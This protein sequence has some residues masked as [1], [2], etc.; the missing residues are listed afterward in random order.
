MN[1]FSETRQHQGF[2]QWVKPEFVNRILCALLMI[3]L[4]LPNVSSLQA[5]DPT[6]ETTK[7]ASSQ[8]RSSNSSLLSQSESPDHPT[9]AKSNQSE[10]NNETYLT[11]EQG[12]KIPVPSTASLEEY[13]QWLKN[14]D[15]PLYY[16]TSVSLEGTTIDNQAALT[17][18]IKLHLN[19]DEEWV[20]VPLFLNEAILLKESRYEGKGKA[21]FDSWQKEKGYQWW[22]QGK[23]EHQLRFSLLVPI[24][25]QMPIHRLQLKIPPC[26]ASY[27]KLNVPMDRISVSPATSTQSVIKTESQ[28]GKT[29]QVE[30]FGLTEAL[31]L[32]WKQLP[33]A[34]KVQTILQAFTSIT[35]DITS[36]SVLLSA[37][38]RIQVLGGALSQITVHLPQEYELLEVE[39]N[40]APTTNYQSNPKE[41]HLVTLMFSED[42]TENVDVRWVMESPLAEQNR[43]VVVTGFQVD[44]TR[45]ESGEVTV[46]MQEGFRISKRDEESQFVYRI[47]GSDLI[48]QEAKNF[49][50]TVR[51]IQSYR[52]LKQPFRLTV[53]LLQIQPYFSATPSYKI[54]VTENEIQLSGEIRIQVYRGSLD[55]VTLLWPETIPF[56]NVEITEGEGL[57]ESTQVIQ[58]VPFPTREINGKPSPPVVPLDRKKRSQAHTQEGMEK[59]TPQFLLK[60]SEGNEMP[61]QMQT[62]FRIRFLNRQS[63]L[64]SIPIQATLKLPSP[65]EK[66]NNPSLPFQGSF[67]LPTVD[68]TNVM[69]TKLSVTYGRNVVAQISP[70]KGTQLRSMSDRSEDRS[71]PATYRSTGDVL[72]FQMTGQIHERDL[73]TKTSLKIAPHGEHLHLEETISYQVRYESL[74]QIRLAVPELHRRQSV[75]FLLNGTIPLTATWT[76]VEIGSLSEVR[77]ALPED[78][79]ETF[80]I[81][82]SFQLP[83]NSLQDHPE[84]EPWILPLIQSSDQ[85]FSETRVSIGLNPRYRVEVSDINQ[86]WSFTIQND[87]R[88]WLIHTHRSSIP[89]LVS[90][91]HNL[92]SQT[93]RITR[94]Y[95]RSFFDFEGNTRLHS[96][97]LIEGNR[98]SLLLSLPYD[99]L[100]EGIWWDQQSISLSNLELLDADRNIYQLLLPSENVH[101]DSFK[102]PP[103]PAFD[104]SMKS[105]THT[106]GVENIP[107]HLLTVLIQQPQSTSFGR[108]SNHSLSLI[109]FGKSVQIDEFIWDVTIP[110]RTLLWSEPESWT[111]LFSWQR[112]GFFWQR[113]PTAYDFVIPSHLRP[114]ILSPVLQGNS[115]RFQRFGQQSHINFT[116]IGRTTLLLL[117]GSMALAFGA[118][119]FKLSVTHNMITLLGLMF[120]ATLS[121]FFFPT[122]TWLLIQPAILGLTLAAVTVG[123]EKSRQ[124]PP[125]P[126]LIMESYSGEHSKGSQPEVVLET[127]FVGENA[128]SGSSQQGSGFEC[129]MDLSDSE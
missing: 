6:T 107:R 72:A 21:S 98:P 70:N 31:D 14:R 104:S 41:P 117:G 94:A 4:F 29:T 42:I 97:Y 119:L 16:I 68:A 124:S 17:A 20:R 56:W 5:Q 112:T 106:D 32:Q 12:K 116:T 126:P 58:S 120:V 113:T 13:L 88:D 46:R 95:V 45:R 66:N 24:R 86:E 78:T 28:K 11:N 9:S 74:D 83:L 25:K 52:F 71:I 48:H 76:G 121:A 103:Q 111:P 44:K 91:S 33:Q 53:E 105:E 26:T 63:G 96:E 79:L 125:R 61:I 34:Q 108:W 109:S 7:E 15:N 118:I 51:P 37:S 77:L 100:P 50:N 43:E 122:E 30:V 123:I 60:A 10:E 69:P 81:V 114:D 101:H 59:N 87:H 67:T 40:G 62:S 8:N 18:T 27:L 3:F 23:G 65:V 75:G 80:D 1:L 36:E 128:Q 54:H 102:N 85:P 90:R 99:Q 92:Q 64:F 84:S 19:R 115:Y 39:V 22:F 82:A 73:D 127:T 38:Q 55:E 110:N 57:I 93:L 35:A 2:G 49:I 47:N 89:L 129:P